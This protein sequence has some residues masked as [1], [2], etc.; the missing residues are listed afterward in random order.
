MAPGT[1][2]TVVVTSRVPI[3]IVLNHNNTVSAPT[4]FSDAA[5]NQD[6]WQQVIAQFDAGVTR[7]HRH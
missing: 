1:G 5:L 2:V 3:L 7:Q 6:G 4:D